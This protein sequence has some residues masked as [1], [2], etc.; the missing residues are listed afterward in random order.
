LSAY[1]PQLHGLPWVAPQVDKPQ[2]LPAV[3]PLPHP[4]P[5]PQVGSLACAVFAGAVCSALTKF[6]TPSVARTSTPTMIAA[7]TVV[8]I[9]Y[10]PLGNLV[11]LFRKRLVKSALT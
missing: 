4:P 5:A 11:N 1:L 9:F 2:L 10:P 7:I 8:F 6:T 3:H